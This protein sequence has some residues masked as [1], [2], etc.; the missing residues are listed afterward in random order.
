MNYL[1]ENDILEYADFS[2]KY[3][4]LRYKKDSHSDRIKAIEKR[5][6]ELDV[7]IK[8]IEVYQTK[9]IVDKLNTVVFKEKYRK[10]NESDF[11]LFKAAERSLKPHIKDGK[12]PLIKPLRAEINKLYAEKNSLYSEYDLLKKDF[13]ELS[14]IKQNVNIILG[15]ADSLERESLRKRSSELE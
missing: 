4:S 6:K 10:E 13:S 5:I 7:L 14:K 3:E 1:T 11:I 9:P 12:P 2:E 15:K 8:D